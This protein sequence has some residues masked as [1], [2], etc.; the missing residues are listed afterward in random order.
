MP[1]EIPV[2][3][4]RIG[5]IQQCTPAENRDINFP[6]KRTRKRLESGA[7]QDHGTHVGMRSKK[8]RSGTDKIFFRFFIDRPGRI[9][10]LIFAPEIFEL[11]TVVIIFSTG[12]VASEDARAFLT[13][14]GNPYL[15]KPFEL[16]AMRRIVA[17]MTAPTN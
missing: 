1:V 16:A 10:A 14:T 3:G 8:L 9:G 13:R 17:Q 12:D 2:Y 15:Q 5:I 4:N 6:L 7:F 11:R